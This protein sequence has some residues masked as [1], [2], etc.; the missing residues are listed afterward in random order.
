MADLSTTIET[1][2]GEPLKMQGDAGSVE[3][4]K[5]TDL[6]EADRYLGGKDATAA[7][8]TTLPIRLFKLSP[9]GAV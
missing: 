6:I 5:L 4:H 3:Q 1:V 2:A 8:Q 9:P 7:T